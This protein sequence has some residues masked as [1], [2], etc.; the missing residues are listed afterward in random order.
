[1]IRLYNLQTWKIMEIYHFKIMSEIKLWIVAMS[2][3][4][5]YGLK[6]LITLR[7]K[8]QLVKLSQDLMWKYFRLVL[9][10]WKSCMGSLMTWRLIMTK[11]SSTSET[12]CRWA[13]WTR[14]NIRSLIT[15]GYK[16]KLVHGDYIFVNNMKV[17]LKWNTRGIDDWFAA[18]NIRNKALSN[19][20]KISCTYTNKSWFTVLPTDKK[21]W[22]L[23]LIG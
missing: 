23:F 15:Q 4:S 10:S 17:I 1:M 7:K 9:F 22:W 12:Q 14:R 19:F 5:I 8:L 3:F 16:N 2:S 13:A 21:N 20:A 18:I 6:A 11:P